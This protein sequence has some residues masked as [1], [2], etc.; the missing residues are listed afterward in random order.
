M[1]SVCCMNWASIVIAG[2]IAVIF[3]VIALVFPGS[4]LL[5]AVAA[6]GIFVIL[7]SLVGI[8]K[9]LSHEKKTIPGWALILLGIFG[10][11]I[12]ISAFLLPGITILVIII[13]IAVWA[14]LTGISEIAQ[15]IQLKGEPGS[16]RAVLALSGILSLILGIF[17]VLFPG[18]GAVVLI[19]VIGIYAVIFGILGI[20]YGFSLK[21]SAPGVAEMAERA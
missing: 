15:A 4:I 12:G 14:L 8:A 19:W 6:L 16:K 20:V 2:I 17:L 10:I 13:W 11:V 5:L 7:M 21:K 18:A 1:E 9:G 3:G